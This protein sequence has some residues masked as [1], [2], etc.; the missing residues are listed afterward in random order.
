LTVQRALE[1]SVPMPSLIHSGTSWRY[2]LVQ[3]SGVDFSIKFWATLKVRKLG[4]ETLW[5][6]LMVFHLMC[7]RQQMKLIFPEGVRS[8]FPW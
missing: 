5:Q 1:S 8:I 7:H 2:Y 3:I 6:L 4:S